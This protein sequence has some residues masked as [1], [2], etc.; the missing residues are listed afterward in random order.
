M[1]GT[2][3][4]LAAAFRSAGDGSGSLFV[5]LTRLGSQWRIGL[6]K[7]VSQGQLRVAARSWK[8]ELLSAISDTESECTWCPHKYESETF[9]LDKAGGFVSSGRR[10][11]REAM[12]PQKI[13]P[14][15]LLTDR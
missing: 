4:G 5:M 11:L 2:I 3:A 6:I 14:F 7:R 12:Q 13:A 9:V 8:V 1:G 10:V 15:P